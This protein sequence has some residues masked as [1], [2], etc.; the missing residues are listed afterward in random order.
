MRDLGL[1]LEDGHESMNLSVSAAACKPTHARPH[2]SLMRSRCGQCI[3]PLRPVWLGARR[4]TKTLECILAAMAI[5]HARPGQS[6]DVQ[7]LGSDLPK[8]KTSALFK[9]VDLE[10]M[11]LVLL[12]GKSLPPHK[13][14]GEI[15]IHCLEGALSVAAEGVSHV[16]LA[17][18]LLYLAGNVV[19]DVTALEDAS[20]LVTVALK[21]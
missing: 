19:H 20:A 17:G 14:P 13:V 21:K 15:T 2:L 18:H 7:P 9:S 4:G 6:I 5:E 11:R 3:M 12:A 1:H 8:V 10:V 16:L